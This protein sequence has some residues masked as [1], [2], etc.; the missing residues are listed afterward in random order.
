MRKENDVGLQK[1]GL[2][3]LNDALKRFETQEVG[4]IGLL[5]REA[6]PSR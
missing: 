3:A 4:E 2:A 5:S 6:L 1:E